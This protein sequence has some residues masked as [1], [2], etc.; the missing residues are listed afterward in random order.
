MLVPF[1]STVAPDTGLPAS[2]V[3][4]PDT[5]KLFCEKAN[6]VMEKNNISKTPLLAKAV[7]LFIQQQF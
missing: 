6:V 5:L 7:F 3:T 4:F 1:T 2:S